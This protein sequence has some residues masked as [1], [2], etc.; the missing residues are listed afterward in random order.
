MLIGC[1]YSLEYVD[2]SQVLDG[3]CWLVAGIGWSIMLIGC[4]YWLEYVDWLQVLVGVC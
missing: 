1:R 2:W 4:R 3:V